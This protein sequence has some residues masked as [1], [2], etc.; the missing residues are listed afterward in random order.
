MLP[1]MFIQKRKCKQTT[2]KIFTVNEQ[3]PFLTLL[4]HELQCNNAMT[5]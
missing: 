3:E 4:G 5:F 2:V 1:A